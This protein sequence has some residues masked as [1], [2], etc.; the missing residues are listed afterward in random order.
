MKCESLFSGKVIKNV[1][2]LLSAKSTQRM[3]KVKFVELI[4]ST[5][6]GFVFI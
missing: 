4:L 6:K 5:F 1:I 3:V 2:N